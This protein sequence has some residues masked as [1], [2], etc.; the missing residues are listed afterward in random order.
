[1]AWLP[2]AGE[3]DPAV[4]ARPRGPPRII[5]ARVLPPAAGCRP[6]TGLGMLS[7][8]AG[9][10]SAAELRP[11]EVTSDGAGYCRGRRGAGAAE[12]REPGPV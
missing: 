9:C 12:D 7:R 2:W 6:R 5:Q 8:P 1:M 10:G 4:L 11:G 3:R